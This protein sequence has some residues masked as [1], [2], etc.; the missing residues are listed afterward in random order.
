MRHAILHVL[1]VDQPCLTVACFCS[2]TRTVPSL[3]QEMACLIVFTIS[4]EI[5]YTLAQY[6]VSWA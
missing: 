5:F 6:Q 3:K 2:L 4:G 1:D